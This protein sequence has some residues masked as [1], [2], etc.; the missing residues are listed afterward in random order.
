LSNIGKK[1]DKAVI[2][3][4][5]RLLNWLPHLPQNER[6][7]LVIPDT[8]GM[9]RTF[10]TICYNDV[11][12]RACYVDIGNNT[13]AHPGIADALAGK[14]GLRRLGLMNAGSTGEDDLDMGEDLITTIRNRLREYTDSQLLLEFLANA[15]D[16]GATEFDVLLD[17]KHSPDTA[18]ISPH[19]RPFQ[20]TPSLVIHN[21]SVFSEEDFKGI[22][23]TGVGGKAGRRDT[24]G[25]FGLGALTMFHVTEV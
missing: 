9:L 22:L 2:L 19:C 11:G 4:V 1:T 5:I 8:Q 12:T 20:R 7:R 10:D 3:G 6:T 15:S 17:E 21:N 25:Q 16:A 14:L 24:I 18:L 23:R 13:L